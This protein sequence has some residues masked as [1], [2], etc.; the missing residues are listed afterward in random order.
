[1]SGVVPPLSELRH[2]ARDA[3]ECDACHEGQVR[4]FCTNHTPVGGPMACV[5]QCKA[6]YGDSRAAR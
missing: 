6:R 4:Y 3:G 1:M 2:D 5:A